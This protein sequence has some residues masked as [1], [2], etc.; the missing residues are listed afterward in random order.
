[1]ITIPSRIGTYDGIQPNP[2]GSLISNLPKLYS[3]N[4]FDL[5]YRMDFLA[6]LTLK[7]YPP[8]RAILFTE[9]LG[10]AAEF[11]TK[12]PTLT[13]LGEQW[14]TPNGQVA[15]YAPDLAGSDWEIDGNLDPATRYLLYDRQTVL[16]ARQ[17][18][19][20][21]T[22]GGYGV[23]FSSYAGAGVEL[24]SFQAYLPFGGGNVLWDYGI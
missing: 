7:G 24:S 1:M 16:F 20:L 22:T 9:G 5:S 21:L 17:K 14:A 23:A 8:N 2:C 19:S 4:S 15:G 18:L 3:I 6:F 11:Y 12:I 10:I 13:I